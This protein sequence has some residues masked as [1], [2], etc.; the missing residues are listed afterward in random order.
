M[1][2]IIFVLNIHT[3]S[4]FPQ[5][6]FPKRKKDETYPPLS[7]HFCR[8]EAPLF[9][10]CDVYRS[11]YIHQNL[12]EAPSHPKWLKNDSL[13]IE[14]LLYLL[15]TINSRRPRV[16]N[17]HPREKAMKS[18]VWSRDSLKPER[19]RSRAMFEIHLAVTETN[20]T[21]NPL[22]S[23]SPEFVTP[24]RTLCFTPR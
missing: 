6:I 16:L 11:R 20:S 14:A 24:D 4:T 5:L 13:H 23:S 19:T 18:F 22:S 10:L 9:W 12:S 1:H 3:H 21:M 17:R 8:T 15:Q 7:I 2:Q